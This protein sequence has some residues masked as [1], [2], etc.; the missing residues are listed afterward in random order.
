MRCFR[1]LVISRQVVVNL[2]SGRAI[3]GALVDQQGPLLV[4][5][6]AT[7]LEPGSEPINVDGDVI[8]ERSQVDFIQA[9]NR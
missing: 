3:A 6:S 4:L 5:K 7:I 8:I 9:L 1:R 2:T